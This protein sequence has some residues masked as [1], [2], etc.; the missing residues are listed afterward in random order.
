MKIA[1]IVVL[2]QAMEKDMG[3]V[4]LCAKYMST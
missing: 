2:F 1:N 3:H 4:S